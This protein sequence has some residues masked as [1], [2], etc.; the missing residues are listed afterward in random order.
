MREGRGP[1]PE[2]A[3]QGD[4]NVPPLRGC[5]RSHPVPH[6]FTVGYVVTSLRDFER[7]KSSTPDIKRGRKFLGDRL[8][9]RKPRWACGNIYECVRPHTIG[10]FTNP[11]V[12]HCKP[13]TSRA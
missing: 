13:A 9:A 3:A 5:E 2:G 4:P 7:H 10:V 1:S 8:F 11:N 6:R 12:T